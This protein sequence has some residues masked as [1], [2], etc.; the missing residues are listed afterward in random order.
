MRKVAPLHASPLTPEPTLGDTVL[1]GRERP[2]HSG[3]PI[4]PSLR[5]NSVSFDVELPY[6]P[7]H[8]CTESEAAELNKRRVEAIGARAR[9]MIAQGAS[10]TEL[11]SMAREFVFRTPPYVMPSDPA[12]HEAL[13][14]ARAVSKERG[15]N[16]P[17]AIA[18]LARSEAVQAEA[19]RRIEHQQEIISS[20]L[21]T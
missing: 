2:P 1:S 6:A 16:D 18:R 20:L 7:G 12:E 8:V 4:M 11:E 17:L 15:I 21:R 3:S 14:I 19:S 13:K 10:R 9:G 5:V